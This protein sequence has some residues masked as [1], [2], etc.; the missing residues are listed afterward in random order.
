[1]HAKSLVHL[2][3]LN[4]SCLVHQS[5]HQIAVIDF[6]FAAF[7]PRSRLKRLL[8]KP[9]PFAVGD[10]PENSFSARFDPFAADMWCV[11]RLLEL[12]VDKRVRTVASVPSEGANQLTCPVRSR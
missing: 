7:V 12:E 11:G 3:L 5:M 10:W 8:W 6:E 4:Q 2:D 1:M 9:S